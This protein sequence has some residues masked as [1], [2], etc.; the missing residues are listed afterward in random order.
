MTHHEISL[1]SFTN[2]SND[3]HLRTTESNRTSRIC[4]WTNRFRTMLEILKMIQLTDSSE[5]P[6]N[7]WRWWFNHWIQQL[8][9][10]IRYETE[11][12]HNQTI[13]WLRIQCCF[14][15]SEKRWWRLVR[16][17]CK[18][19]RIE[20]ETSKHNLLWN[21]IVFYFIIT[22]Q[23]WKTQQRTQDLI[24]MNKSQTSETDSRKCERNI[25][26]IQQSDS[27]RI[28]IKSS[29]NES[30]VLHSIW[31]SNEWKLWLLWTSQS[32]KKW[33]KPN[34]ASSEFISYHKR[35]ESTTN[36]NNA[37]VLRTLWP[38]VQILCECVGIQ[39]QNKNEQHQEQTQILYLKSEDKPNQRNWSCRWLSKERFLMM[40][41]FQTYKWLIQMRM[42]QEAHRIWILILSIV[43]FEK[44]D[45]R[46]IFSWRK[47]EESRF[48]I[49]W[50][51]FEP[52][53]EQCLNS[54]EWKRW[55]C[56][57]NILVLPKD[58]EEAL[59]RTIDSRAW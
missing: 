5:W 46:W 23:Q 32:L 39:K 34:R 48:E 54:E 22:Y 42:I 7:Q 6:R 53:L 21:K 26:R 36:H 56:K 20:W 37:Q 57:R 51:R 27:E 14:K 44:P 25:E 1:Y 38:R 58:I 59:K 11:N 24:C 43:F 16:I 8:R 4:A 10:C 47:T 40:I 18:S 30:A 12:S 45:S 3:K 2:T 15:I 9:N 33:K 19:R 50:I 31:Q 28:T 49:S 41:Q 29:L 55:S 13:L 35:N 52:I 17:P